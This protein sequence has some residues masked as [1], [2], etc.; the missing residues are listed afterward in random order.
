MLRDP[1]FL[2]CNVR[3]GGGGGSD[4]AAVAVDEMGKVEEFS[5]EESLTVSLLL[6]DV[7]PLP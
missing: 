4:G 1:L 7:T 6:L 5:E 3:C 2:P